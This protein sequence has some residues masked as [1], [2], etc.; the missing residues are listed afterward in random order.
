MEK[1]LEREWKKGVKKMMSNEIKKEEELGEIQ[2]NLRELMMEKVREKDMRMFE[3]IEDK[4]FRKR[5]EG[6]VDLRVMVKELMIQEMR[7]GFE[8]GLMIVM[9]FMVI[10]IVVEKIKM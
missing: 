10:E 6:I 4:Q 7:R 1:E 9:K 2:K 3:E 8:I 5:D